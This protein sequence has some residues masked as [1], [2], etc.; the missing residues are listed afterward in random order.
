MADSPNVI[1]RDLCYF[2][3]NAIF[4]RI[5]AGDFCPLSAIPVQSKR[6]AQQTILAE[7]KANTHSPNIIACSAGDAVQVTIY[8]TFWAGYDA[9]TRAIPVLS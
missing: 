1:R 8:F 7:V 5:V 6:S 3:E 2:I 9:P 4:S